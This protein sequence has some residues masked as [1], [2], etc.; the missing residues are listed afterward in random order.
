MTTIFAPVSTKENINR[1]N[2]NNSTAWYKQF[3]PWFLITFPATAVIAGIITVI[4][5]MNSDDGLVKDDYYKAGLAI[6]QTLAK[7]K[8][9]KDLGI[10]AKAQLDSDTG[11]IR[12][13]L[14]HNLESLPEQ[15]TLKLMHATRANQ[16]MKV[17]L[18]LSPDQSV[19]TG[20]LEQITTGNW[21][22]TIEP[23]DQEWRIQG[24]VTLPAQAQ[25]SIKP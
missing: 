23:L 16:D 4:L 14:A 7:S 6:N 19:Y 5:A 2:N 22:S 21:I 12:I 9:A 24:R 25:W 1:M 18:Y 11:S 17:I 10:L 15:L 3:W 13:N 8:L 20:R